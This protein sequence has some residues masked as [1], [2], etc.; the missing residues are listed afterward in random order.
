MT[1]TIEGAATSTVRAPDLTGQATAFQRLAAEHLDAA[2]RLARAILHDPTDVGKNKAMSGMETV[3]RL[4]PDDCEKC[5]RE[6]VAV[7]T[8][9]G[10]LFI[11]GVGGSAAVGL[12]CGGMLAAF[13][14]LVRPIRPFRPLQQSFAP[15]MPSSKRTASGSRSACSPTSATSWSWRS[16]YA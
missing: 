9:G 8:R 7:R 5:V 10:R 12:L 2:Y 13:A 3:A 16:S 11:L 15:R 6:L 1:G 4:N 14:A